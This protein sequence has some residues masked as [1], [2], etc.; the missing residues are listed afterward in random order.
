MS[1]DDEDGKKKGLGV[2]LLEVMK[3]DTHEDELI[4]AFKE[5]LE[6][7]AM[8][9]ADLEVGAA[10]ARRAPCPAPARRPG[11]GPR[12]AEE[13]AEPDPILKPYAPPAYGSSIAD[14]SVRLQCRPAPQR[15]TPPRPRGARARRCDRTESHP[16]RAWQLDDDIAG[17]RSRGSARAQKRNSERQQ[18]LPPAR[19]APAPEPR[20]RAAARALPTCPRFERRRP[21]R[22]STVRRRRAPRT[23][24]RSI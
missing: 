15:H 3:K 20:T 13:G 21:W 12:Q 19:A 1:S 8:T 18:A 7:P 24:P 6:Q 4:E 2:V 16:A 22:C 10:A 17:E 9:L 23:R 5:C 14:W 11:R